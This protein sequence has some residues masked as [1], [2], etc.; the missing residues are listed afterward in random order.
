MTVH[1]PHSELRET[2]YSGYVT[3]RQEHLV[4]SMQEREPRLRECRKIIRQHFPEDRGASILD[5]GCGHGVFLHAAR[6]EGYEDVRGV[7]RSP[8]QVEAAGRLG[9][10]G[11]EQGRP[12]RIPGGSAGRQ[13]GCDNCVG[14]TG[15][16]HGRRTG[17][18]R[19][20]QPQGAAGRRY[21]AGAHAEWG[22]SFRIAHAS[23]GHHAPALFHSDLAGAAF[24]VIRVFVR[25]KLRRPDCGPWG[26]KRGTMGD[27]ENDKND[28]P[29]LPG[30]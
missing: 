18:V 13:R 20:G 1:D 9:I 23:L 2:V 22:I 3:Q 11:V 25:R 16:F 14:Y 4:S 5:L 17:I 7:D 21:P 19:A 10:E 6:Q 26:E 15:A 29:V 24:P 27:V 8:E 28:A 30:G 12:V